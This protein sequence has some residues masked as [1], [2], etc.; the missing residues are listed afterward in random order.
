M[1]LSL[2]PTYGLF[3]IKN[4][5]IVTDW[6]CCGQTH[7]AYLIRCVDGMIWFRRCHS[8]PSEKSYNNVENFIIIVWF[9]FVFVFFFITSIAVCPI[10]F[11]SLGS[12]WQ[13]IKWV[14]NGWLEIIWKW[15]NFGLDL[16]T[17]ELIFSNTVYYLKLLSNKFYSH[18][19][20]CCSFKFSFVKLRSMKI[21]PKLTYLFLLK[22]K[23]AIYSHL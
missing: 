2:P 8:L 4:S 10:L 6:N 3:K 16:I 11:W 18:N 5:L 14:N 9:C 13:F 12:K 7:S 21:L 23:R 17:I 1:F 20:V 22:K 15:M 19:T